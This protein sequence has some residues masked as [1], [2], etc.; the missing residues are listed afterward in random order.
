MKKLDISVIIPTM[1]REHSLLRTLEKLLIYQYVPNEIII[2][3]QSDVNNKNL[4][5]NLNDKLEYI[6]K[7]INIKHIIQEKPSLTKARNIGLEKA[8]NDIIIFMDDDVDVMKDTLK[9][10]YSIMNDKNISMIAGIDILDTNSNSK[11]GYIFGTKSITKK[12]IGHVNKSMFG[13]FPYNIENLEGRCCTEWAMGFFFVVRKS[14]I[15][16]WNIRWDERLISYA[17]AEDLD[18]S[19]SYYKKSKE[20][21]LQCI[22]DSSVKVQHNCS[23]EWRVESKKSTFMYVINREYLSYKHYPYDFIRIRTR[24]SN[25]GALIQ[26]I[27]QKDNYK[28]FIKAMYYCEKYRKDIKNGI[29]HYELYE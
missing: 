9:N 8:K 23:R 18:F 13:R 26:R 2:V 25:I 4:I 21:N 27:V 7:D 19:F 29:L 12:N 6:K 24:W 1:N 22:M 5:K 3:D 16:K 28:D 10:V 15:N 17:Y 20:E 11:I 14:L